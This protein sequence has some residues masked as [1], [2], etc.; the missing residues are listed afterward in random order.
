MYDGA[1][2][3]MPYEQKLAVMRYMPVTS[4]MT[5]TQLSQYLQDVQ[6]AYEGRVRLEFPDDARWAA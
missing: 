6:K 1:L 2:K 3:S 5:T 4:I